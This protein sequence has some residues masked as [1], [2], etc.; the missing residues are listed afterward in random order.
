MYRDQIRSL[1]LSPFLTCDDQDLQ[2]DLEVLN[3]SSTMATLVKIEIE[4]FRMPHWLPGNC[5]MQDGMETLD[6]DRAEDSSLRRACEGLYNALKTLPTLYIPIMEF[7]V[8]D[9]Y[10]LLDMLSRPGLHENLATM[11]DVGR[12]GCERVLQTIPGAADFRNRLMPFQV[13]LISREC[14][15]AIRSLKASKVERLVNISGIVIQV[16][17]LFVKA[18]ILH[19]RCKDCGNSKTL[20]IPMW[21]E[22]VSLPRSCEGSSESKCGLDPFVIINEDCKFVDVQN[23]KLQELPDEVPTGDIPRHLSL[24]LTNGLV[25]RVTA[26]A[27]IVACGIYSVYDR[28]RGGHGNTETVKAAYLHVLGID[29]RTTQVLNVSLNNH[30]MDQFHF[31][32]GKPDII[33]LIAKSIAPSIYGLHDIK[34]SVSCM[35]FGGSRKSLSDGSSLRGDIHLLL[36]GDPST[37]KSQLLKFVE[38]AAPIAVYTSGKGSSAAGLTAALVRDMNGNYALEGGAMVLADGGVVCIDEFDKMR[39][40]DR[41]AIHEAME[42]QTISIAKAGINTV[43]TTQCAVIAAAN[44]TFGCYDDTKDASDQHNFETTILSRF[45]CIWLVRDERDLVR[46]KLLAQHIFSLYTSVIDQF[47]N[48][49]SIAGKQTIKYGGSGSRNGSRRHHP[50]SFVKGLYHTL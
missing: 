21:K 41:V 34:K 31:L 9:I 22:G 49:Y 16:S 26:G 46:D 17:K 38:K 13:E 35:L 15:M 3:D 19:I 8:R 7:V 29:C 1:S 45:D 5:Q 24:N 43:L 48:R 20:K 25:N 36:L 27:R 4:H 6:F 37:A 42:Q 30:T 14:P 44:P 40:D 32:A 10:V 28:K 50:T 12:H 47:L 11:E 2:Q 18:V 23:I 39:D 33:E